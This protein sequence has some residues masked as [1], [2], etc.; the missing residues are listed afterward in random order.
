MQTSSRRWGFAWLGLVA[1]LAL[2]VTD[3]AVNGF[4]PLYNQ[5]VT[6]LRRSIGWFP[7]P[8]FTFDGWLAGLVTA[9]LVLLSLSPLVFAGQ[10]WLRPAADVFAV[11]LAANAVAHVAVSLYS[12]TWAPGVYSSPVMFVAALALFAETR[13]LGAASLE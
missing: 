1:A 10:R 4:V 5:V 9:I 3:E 12:G 7:M 8:A 13:R 6:D 11:V 2:H